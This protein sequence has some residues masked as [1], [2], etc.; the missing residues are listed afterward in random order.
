MW[1]V[2]RSSVCQRR[3]T[4][5]LQHHHLVGVVLDGEG[6][7]EPAVAGVPLL[8]VGQREDLVSG[9]RQLVPILHLGHIEVAAIL[10]ARVLLVAGLERQTL[11]AVPEDRRAPTD[12]FCQSMQRGTFVC[13]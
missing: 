6:E 9:L 1:Y 13:C 11:N 12:R 5:L 8:A 2:I 3:L 7:V 4:Q 10:L